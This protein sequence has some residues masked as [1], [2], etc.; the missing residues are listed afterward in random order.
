MSIQIL[1]HNARF[2]VKR[3]Y[4]QTFYQIP[5]CSLATTRQVNTFNNEGM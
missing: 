2:T 5:N 4:N 3:K 1:K